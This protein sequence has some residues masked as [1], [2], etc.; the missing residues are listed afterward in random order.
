MIA[1]LSV[2][3]LASTQTWR[4]IAIRREYEVS[5]DLNYGTGL[6]LAREESSTGHLGHQMALG[7]KYLGPGQ[8]VC[9]LYQQNC[10]R[11]SGPKP[12]ISR[13]RLRESK[14]FTKRV[15]NRREPKDFPELP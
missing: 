14:S 6:P 3:M 7:G 5:R 4:R 13:S 1:V 11:S 15:I 2:P 9:P 12:V 8:L 10:R